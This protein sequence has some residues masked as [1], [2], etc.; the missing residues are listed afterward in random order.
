M[1]I[2]IESVRRMTSVNRIAFK[3]KK[4]DGLSYGVALN[5][6]SIVEMYENEK[7]MKVELEL[8][9]VALA[10]KIDECAAKDEAIVAARDALYT[11]KH[12]TNKNLNAK[13]YTLEAALAALPA[14][15]QP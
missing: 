5:P 6:E 13:M 11:W 12:D 9:R 10:D 7:T 4:E 15:A 8:R 1:S 14:K 2:I 3:Y